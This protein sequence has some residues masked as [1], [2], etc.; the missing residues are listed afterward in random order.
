[1][2]GFGIISMV[3]MSIIHASCTSVV[4]CG[5]APD[6]D[7]PDFALSAYCKS[8]CQWGHGGNLCNCHAAYFAGKRRSSSSGGDD[9]EQVPVAPGRY[10][11][12]N[13]RSSVD[14]DNIWIT[15]AAERRP[16]TLTSAAADRRDGET[17]ED[18]VE[19]KWWTATEE[20]RRH[21]RSATSN[22][23]GRSP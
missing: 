12:V 10:A 23:R 8:M 22:S 19:R 3:V 18:D 20:L 6:T 21:L 13:R 14:D 15:L 1:M 7:S 16:L 2:S 9:G 5:D 17:A 11:G 4:N